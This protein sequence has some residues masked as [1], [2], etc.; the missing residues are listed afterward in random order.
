M[1]TTPTKNPAPGN[2]LGNLLF[3][4]EKFDEFITT[5]K[6]SCADTFGGIY[7]TIYGINYDAMQG[8][9]KYGYITKKSSEIGATLDTLD[10]VLQWE[11][12]GEY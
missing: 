4:A 5:Y 2:S 7:R 11:G 3:N 1:V 6:Y 8:M 12:K 9:I 10:T